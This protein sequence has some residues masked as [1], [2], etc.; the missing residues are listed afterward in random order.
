MCSLVTW[1]SVFAEAK[2]VVAA[3]RDELYARPSSGPLLWPGSPRLVAPRDDLAGGT[4]WALSERGLFVGVTNR[5]G[6]P[7]DPERKSRGQLVLDIARLASLDEAERALSAIGPHDYNG[8]HLLAT[9]GAAGV[10]AIATE[11]RL[12]VDR[13]GPGMHVITERSFGAPHA[14][15]DG[16]VERAF[17]PLRDVPIDVERM[18]RTLAIHHDDPLSSVCV[19]VEAFAYG[20]RSSTI[21]AL[22]ERPLLLFADGPPCTT[23]FVDRSELVRSLQRGNGP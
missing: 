12:K 15:R 9:D 14:G 17:E 2:L 16:T 21:L 6:L 11:E 5:A 13:V 19:H 3:N 23:P 4:W 18:K 8:F 20:T 22:G 1:I 10:R 7:P